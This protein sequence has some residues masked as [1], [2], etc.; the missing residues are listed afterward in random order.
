MQVCD[1]ALEAGETLISV[2][3]G[4]TAR[5]II[6]D[7]TSGEGASVRVHILAKSAARKFDDVPM[8][9]LHA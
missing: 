8:S 7:T 3:A 5:W 2:S 4:D 9:I 6:G 1:I